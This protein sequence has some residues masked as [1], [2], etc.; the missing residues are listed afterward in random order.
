MT[1]N[2][3][4][5]LQRKLTLAPVAKA[6]EGLAD[7]I[8]GEIPLNLRFEPEHE[9]ARLWQSASF[10][11]RIAASIVLLVSSL[12]FALHLLSRS[13]SSTTARAMSE[14]RAATPA[15][16]PP[17]AIVALP[18]IPP[19]PG[20]ARL[21]QAADQPSLPSTPPGRIAS[22]QLK[23]EIAEKKREE[24]DGMR[25]GA[26][27]F[28]DTVETSP[29]ASPSATGSLA[30][31]KAAPLPEIAT[32]PA[33]VEGGSFAPER[34]RADN[35]GAKT[36]AAHSAMPSPSAGA[37]APPPPLRSSLRA[38]ENAPARSF[39]AI[40]ES[41][42]RGENPRNVD[43]AAI[44]RHFAAPE[45]APSD[46]RVE[47]EA[48]STPLDATK[49]L[50]RVSVDAPPSRNAAITLTFGDAI[51]AQRALS[52]SAAPNETAL[53][54]IEFK[55]NAAPDQTIATVKAGG[56]TRAVRI[57]DLHRW[58]DASPRMK[59]AS[60]AAAWARTLQSRTRADAIVARAREAHIDDLAD[61]AE[62]AERNR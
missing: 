3:K 58:N 35:A 32:E 28:V 5:D 17:S 18:N 46:V 43:V 62:Q 52:G 31:A 23:D 11:L 24:S 38:K 61:L 60:L 12:Y 42:E 20:S 14:D 1:R 50:L 34:A 6:P 9:R 27:A 33:A 51:S 10:N 22:A 37:A 44:V 21:R 55:R 36:M 29:S 48:S 13:K 15:A 59:R 40:E 25:A 41:I 45:R 56:V 30:M 26:P 16:A 7:R 49:W 8:K 47:V 39:D 4:A 54:E 19:Q 2:R 53:Y 57:S